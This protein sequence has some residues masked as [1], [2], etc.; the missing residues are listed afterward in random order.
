MGTGKMNVDRFDPEMLQ[1]L[2]AFID[3]CDNRQED[4]IRILHEAQAIFGYLPQEVQLYVARAVNLPAAKIN[5]IVTFYS[6]FSEKP[7]G[8]YKVSICMG[9]ACFVKGSAAV[10]AALREH[11]QVNEDGMSADRKSVV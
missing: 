2:D 1:Q 8:K 9:T 11:L 4:V 3:G 6:Y 7:S 10:L 5:G